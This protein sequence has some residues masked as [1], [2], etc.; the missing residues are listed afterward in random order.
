M[1][2]NFSMMELV[3]Q[4]GRKLDK[5][6]KQQLI[7]FY[8][9]FR[10]IPCF[11]QRPLENI[12]KRMKKLPVII[13]FEDGSFASGLNDVKQT[14][15]RNLREFPSISSC[16]AQLTLKNMEKLMSTCDH[17]KKVHYDRKV[18]ALL[19]NAVPSINSHLLQ[20]NGLTGKDVTIAVID[21]GIYPHADLERRI[22]GFQDFVGNQT[23]PYDDNGHGTHCAGDAASNG[24]AS[25]GQ[26]KGPAPEANLVGV[27][28]LNKMGAGSLSTV[29]HG[30]EWCIENQSTNNIDI[31]SLSLGADTTESAEDDP[32]VKAVDAAWDSGMVVCVAAGNSG[33]Q[34]Q[35][36]GSPG[37]SPKVITVGAADDNNN[38]DRSDDTVADFSSRGP[39]IDG[40]TKPDLVTPGVNIVSLRAPNSFIDKTN[41]QARVDSDYIS[42]S[43][44]SMATP[45]CAGVVAQLLQSAPDLTPDEVKAK[46]MEASE[47]LGQ[48]SNVQGSGYLNAENLIEQ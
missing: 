25:D 12:R 5:E 48:P 30:I 44:T 11:L 4:K 46:L 27:K 21:T 42:L 8:K 18:T 17:I 39:T 29:I 9:P 23:D 37:I 32:V 34:E 26:Y 38:T 33:P 35:T 24:S 2:L 41:K 47:D 3:R 7:D 40:I 43:G 14:K 15:C 6:L 31:L 20:E 22:T 13:E 16:S 36:I 10:S 1:V 45:I 28:V 19:D